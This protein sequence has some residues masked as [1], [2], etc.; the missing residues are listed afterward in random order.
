MN[1]DQR[2]DLEK[3]SEEIR[4]FF[5]DIVYNPLENLISQR[6][7]GI[8]SQVRGVADVNSKAIEIYEFLQGD[9][10][11]KLEELE[12]ELKSIQAQMRVQGEGQSQTMRGHLIHEIAQSR[13]SLEEVLS[14]LAIERS[15]DHLACLEHIGACR[16]ETLQARDTI[17]SAL[18]Q[19]D[20]VRVTEHQ[21]LMEGSAIAHQGT[22]ELFVSVCKS[23]SEQTFP[24]LKDRFRA[25]EKRILFAI[26]LASVSVALN[27]ALVIILM[28][29]FR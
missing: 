17:A 24:E 27:V 3:A 14:K 15:G 10:T 22:R 16:Q 25:C 20:A 7:K 8:E 9:M 19:A 11:S 6:L 29:Y 12:S 28:N 5:H 2:A 18:V 1:E 4:R 26:V 21:A 13:V 23:M